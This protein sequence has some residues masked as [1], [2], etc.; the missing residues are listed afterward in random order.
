MS[1]IRPSWLAELCPSWCS[2]DHEG[3]DHPADR[4]HHSPQVLVPVVVP[5][6]G[7]RHRTVA[8]KDRAVEP[9]EFS[10]LA[11]RPVGDEWTTW[12][13]VVGERQFLEVTLES[14]VRLHGA[15]GELL[16]QLRRP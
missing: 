10:V 16:E 9:A 11:L 4:Y 5:T 12:V 8:S 1:E 3:Q 14:A 7:V 13:A 15:L 6:R 2:G